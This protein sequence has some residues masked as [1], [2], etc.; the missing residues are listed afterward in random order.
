MGPLKD[1]G[2]N[3]C[4]EPEEVGEVLLMGSLQVFTKEKDVVDGECRRED[5]NILGHVEMKREEVIEVYS[6]ET[7]PLAQ[8]VHAALFLNP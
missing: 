5:V 1:S 2:G 7:G 3:L 6:M 4:V 8:L